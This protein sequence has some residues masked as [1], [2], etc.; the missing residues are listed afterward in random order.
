MT[1]ALPSQKHIK[2]FVSSDHQTI[3]SL[4]LEL[5][6]I[7]TQR[8]AAA[9]MGI[10]QGTFASL[11]KTPPRFRLGRPLARKVANR[12]GIDQVYFCKLACTPIK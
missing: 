12:L 2:P 8:E 6:I 4:L 11:F 3:H 10:S 1:T 5:L 9:L 7:R